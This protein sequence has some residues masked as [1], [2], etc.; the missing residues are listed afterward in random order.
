MLLRAVCCLS[1]VLSACSTRLVPERRVPQLGPPSIAQGAALNPVQ[2]GTPTFY[3]LTA[4]SMPLGDMASLVL[5]VAVPVS[6]E[7]LAALVLRTARSQGWEV[8]DGASK[9]SDLYWIAWIYSPTQVDPLGSPRL[10]PVAVWQETVTGPAL[11]HCGAGQWALPV[12]LLTPLRS[13]VRAYFGI[14]SRHDS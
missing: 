12:E 3:P 11:L 1:L 8:K 2:V 5:P 13:E 7:Q 9:K 4:L 10:I 14:P 6:A